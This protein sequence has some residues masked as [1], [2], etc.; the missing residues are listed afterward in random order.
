MPLQTTLKLVPTLKDL[1]VQL[2]VHNSSRR[3]EIFSQ[4]S[5]S[6]ESNWRCD[7]SGIA[8]AGHECAKNTLHTIILRPGESFTQ[9]T[10]PI[11]IRGV[12]PGNILFRFG[13]VQNRHDFTSKEIE[14]VY[15]SRQKHYYFN[16]VN[17]G[18]RIKRETD[19]FWSNTVAVSLRKEWIAGYSAAGR[20]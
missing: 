6:W 11:T 20:A 3:Y 7:R 8:L 10:W 13:L 17:V 16:S 18:S 5:C 9:E 4:M 15:H 2:A 1:R 14:Q 19:I 12:K